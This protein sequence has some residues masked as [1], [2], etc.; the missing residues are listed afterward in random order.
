[1]SAGELLLTLTAKGVPIPQGSKKAFVVAGRARM[2]DDNAEALKPWRKTVEK[3]A[4]GAMVANNFQGPVAGAVA[5]A[6]LFQIERPTS[7]KRALPHVRPDLD[8]YQRA[9]LDALTTAGVWKDD[10]QVTTISARKVYGS[11]PGAR[12][13][14]YRDEE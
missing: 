3:A 10:G 14:V 5:V 4:Q 6:V 8:K 9:V 2:I 13:S 7:V 1:M 11:T 12:V